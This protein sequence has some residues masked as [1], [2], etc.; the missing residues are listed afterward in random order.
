[1]GKMSMLAMELDRAR[2]A[3]NEFDDSDYAY[4]AWKGEEAERELATLF[5]D[6]DVAYEMALSSLESAHSQAV[7][8][9]AK[10]GKVPPTLVDYSELRRLVAVKDAAL[11]AWANANGHDRTA[12]HVEVEDAYRKLNAETDR[13]SHQSAKAICDIAHAR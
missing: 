8:F 11:N 13:L 10:V 9:G 4:E 6:P 12:K 3:A 5:G 2:D 7:A 1:M